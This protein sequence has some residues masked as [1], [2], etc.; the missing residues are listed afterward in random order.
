MNEIDPKL[1]DL[2][3]MKMIMENSALK[4]NIEILRK[5]INSLR[6]LSEKIHNE[7]MEKHEKHIDS[8]LVDLIDP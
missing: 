3:F 5:D 6:E 7:I 2:L 4:K 8:I 1:P